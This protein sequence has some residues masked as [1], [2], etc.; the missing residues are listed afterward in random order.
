MSGIEKESDK[1][2]VVQTALFRRN[3]R[4]VRNIQY[5][6]HVHVYVGRCS[7]SWSLGLQVYKLVLVHIHI[8]DINNMLAIVIGAPAPT[9]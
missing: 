4:H 5:V 7:C 6:R 2:G 3:A 1:R 8:H 9:S